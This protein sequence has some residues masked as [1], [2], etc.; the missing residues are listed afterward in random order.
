MGLR[1]KHFTPTNTKTHDAPFSTSVTLHSLD[2]DDLFN[3]YDYDRGDVGE[4]EEAEDRPRDGYVDLAKA[5]LKAF[6]SDNPE[7]VFYQRQL[8]VMLE[9]KYFHWITVRA[10]VELVQEGI[11]AE[12]RL[13][14]P[15]IG[16]EIVLYRLSSYRYWRRDA[17]E[18]AKLVNRFSDPEFTKAVGTHGEMMFDA[19]LP[20]VGFLPKGVKV[21][22]YRN[23]EWTKTKHDLDRVFERDGIGYGTEVKNTLGY[24]EKEEMEVKVD[25]CRKLGLVPLFIVRMAPKSYVKL[26]DDAGGFTLIFKYQLY[27][28][29]QK[30][31][32]D[33]VKERLRLPTDSPV[34]IMEGT[35][36]RFLKWHLKKH[37]LG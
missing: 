22:Q 21:R 9:G 3:W 29:G 25:M 2:G 7:S 16:G 36:Q 26:V 1:R 12:E 31:F 4:R 5:S 13:A 30:A 14:V 23:E 34:R 33:E 19:A 27:P 35:V 32:A 24:I 6:F 37:N 10:L 17:E 20:T 11:I 28:H 8:Q 15:N 18:I